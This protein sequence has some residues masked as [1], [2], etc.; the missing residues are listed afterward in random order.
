[1]RLATLLPA[2]W[3]FAGCA[4]FTPPYQTEGSRVKF[5]NYCSFR[6]T[7]LYAPGTCVDS[8]Y[9]DTKLVTQTEYRQ[10][11]DTNPSH[12]KECDSCPVESVKWQDAD[13]YCRKLGRRLPNFGEWL[14]GLYVGDPEVSNPQSAEFKRFVELTAW[15]AHNSGAETHPVGSLAPSSCGL[16][17]MIG[18]VGQYLNEAKDPSEFTPDQ[19][20]NPRYK[21][22]KRVYGVAGAGWDTFLHNINP[23]RF[24]YVPDFV[25]ES[26]TGFRCLE[27][28]AREES[29]TV[30]WPKNKT[31]EAR[32]SIVPIP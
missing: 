30:A 17:D 5:R 32:S 19:Q 27:P 28:V 25:H 6:A 10:V 23:T 7:H 24:R 9:L 3:I 15:T 11:M 31:S 21:G 8:F 12:H 4:L 29:D 16:Y 1:M 22:A 13:A 26:W 20:K 2:A 18:N 14:Y